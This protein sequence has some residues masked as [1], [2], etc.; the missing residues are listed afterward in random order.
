MHT[1][2]TDPVDAAEVV[3]GCVERTDLSVHPSFSASELGVLGISSQPPLVDGPVI[4][5]FPGAVIWVD[6]S[7]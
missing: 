6:I 7:Q 5:D 1:K 2:L 4:L 3:D